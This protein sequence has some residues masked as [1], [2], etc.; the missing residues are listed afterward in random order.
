MVRQYPEGV[1]AKLVS[2]HV[3]ISSERSRQILDELVYLRELYKRE[4][5]E[6]VNLYY[7]NGK[8]IHKYLQDSKDIGDQIFRISFHEG[9]IAPKIQIQ[10]RK[11]TLLDGEKVEGSIFIDA[12][13]IDEFISFINQMMGKFNSFK[14]EKAK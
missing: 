14:L 7:P 12:E 8:L 1:T 6:K 11:Y 10:E 5:P 4:L 3:G 13:N 9:K 2:N